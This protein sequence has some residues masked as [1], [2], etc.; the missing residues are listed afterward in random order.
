VDHK[1]IGRLMW[2][3]LLVDIL[4]E[5]PNNMSV[6]AKLRPSGLS[7]EYSGGYNRGVCKA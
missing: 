6:L 4:F 1:G 5:M 7:N 3:E 2:P